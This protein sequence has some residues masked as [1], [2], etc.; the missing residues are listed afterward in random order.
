MK[1]FM[2]LAALAFALAAGAMTMM[3][4]HPLDALAD[5]KQGCG[6]PIC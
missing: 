6:G 2:I 3:A 1:K 4:V 5:F